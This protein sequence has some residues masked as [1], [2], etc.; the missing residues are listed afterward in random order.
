MLPLLRFI[1]VVLVLAMVRAVPADESDS[2]AL[3]LTRAAL[4]IDTHID[5]PYRLQENWMDVSRAT[6]D[7]DFDYPRAVAGGLNIPFMSI[8]TPAKSETDGTA[9]QL[10]HQL[11]DNV[12]AL[13]ARAPERFVM[14]HHTK[15]ALQAQAEGKI[16]LALGMENGAPVNGDL[17]NLQQFYD[18]GIRYIT[19]THGNSNH[20]S[21]SSYDEQRPWQG[22]SPFG[23]Q[24][25]AEMNRL[26]IMID[27]SHVSDE[28]FYQVMELSRAPA[29][30]SHS[31]ARHFT[32]G[33]ERNMADD[34]IVKLA[35]KG[36]VIQIN[37]GSS[38][39]TKQA[40]EW[41]NTY[42]D[43]RDEHLAINRWDK[44]SDVA[45]AYSKEYRE[46]NPFPYAKLAD[47]ADHFDHV[48]NLVGIDHIGI[49]SDFD[50]VGDSLPEGLKDVSMYPM[51]VAEL[52]RRGYSESDL[53]KILGG[54]LL[55]VWRQ[56]EA[57]AGQQQ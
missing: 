16:G 33:W 23:R 19:L 47:V 49:G 34:M 48:R 10:A 36:G 13:V 38:F 18:R 45:K 12:E 4:L 3:R 30:A 44:N 24:L 26:G 29:I 17:K 32:P 15:A 46:A 54:N 20:I 41:H 27:I 25:V 11:I 14:V 52:L 51:L 50:G 35:E 8:Y 43:Q 5:V 57:L 2:A 42:S 6:D 53:R 39:I 1:C 21:D 28:A 9:F 22:L 31:S 37:F 40:H 55:R 56:V 7:G